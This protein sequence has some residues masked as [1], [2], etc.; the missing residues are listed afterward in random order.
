MRTRAVENVCYTLSVN[1]AAPHETAPTGLYDPSGRPVC[2]LERNQPGLLI[3]DL[4]PWTPD[5]GQ[6]GRKEISDRLCR[7]RKP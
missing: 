6:R 1:A 2:E 7:A 5:F 4:H 3:H